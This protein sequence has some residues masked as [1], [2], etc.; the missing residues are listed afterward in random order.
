MRWLMSYGL[1]LVMALCVGAWLATGTLVRGGNGPGNGEKQ[2]VSLIEGQEDGPLTKSLGEAGVLAHPP[3]H[4]EIDPH[5]TI[6]ER[7]AETTG[8]GAAAMS[9]RY[10]TSKMQALKIE[11]PLRGRTKAKAAVTASAQTAGI[12]ADVRVS[13]GQSVKAGDLLCV[14]DQGTRAAA[15]KQAEAALLQAQSGVVKAQ[16]DVDTN[17]ELR[18]K[19]L[20]AANTGR[21][22]EVALLSAQSA[23]SSAQSALDNAQAELDRTEIHT[24]VSGVVQDP[25]ATVGSLIATGQPCATVVQLD[26]MLFTGT[27]S[28]ANI[29]LARLGL[30]A[31]VTTIT[32]A[33]AD[34]TVS[35]IAATADDA[36]R[37]FPIEIELPNADGKLRDGVTAEAVVNVGTAPAHLLPQSTLTLDENGILGVRTVED[38]LVAFHAVTIVK[39]TREGV[40]VTGLPATADVITVGQESVQVGQKVKASAAPVAEGAN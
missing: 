4:S 34:G 19:G 14:L 12:V 17:A 2:I 21:P 33:K 23:V 28:E 24:K 16:A 35:F 18:K 15:V 13:K 6:A 9:V 10:M 25:M 8:S 22:L 5:L 1:A 38:S 39:D 30:P 27:V 36:T 20:A 37:A 7:V 32:G 3:E 26:P 40:W 11:V 29:G 31:S